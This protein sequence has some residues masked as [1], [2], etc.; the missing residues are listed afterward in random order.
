MKAESVKYF[1]METIIK[2]SVSVSISLKDMETG[3]DKK[4]MRLK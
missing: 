2:C 1:S 3:N 4:Y